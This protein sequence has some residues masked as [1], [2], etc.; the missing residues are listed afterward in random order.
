MRDRFCAGQE[1]EVRAKVAT[2]EACFNYPIYALRDGACHHT[3]QKKVQLEGEVN[4][5]HYIIFCSLDGWGIDIQQFLSL[6]VR[7]G[8]YLRLCS[9]DVHRTG[10]EPLRGP[11]VFEHKSVLADKWDAIFGTFE[12]QDPEGHGWV[13]WDTHG[14]CHITPGLLDPEKVK[15]GMKTYAWQVSAQSWGMADLMAAEAEEEAGEEDPCMDENGQVHREDLLTDAR[16]YRTNGVPIVFSVE[17]IE[18]EEDV[19]DG[20]RPDDLYRNYR[21][22]GMAVAVLLRPPYTREEC[23][24]RCA[25]AVRLF[26]AGVVPRC[27]SEW[28]CYWG[29]GQ[30]RP[31]QSPPPPRGLQEEL[32]AE[33]EDA[34]ANIARMHPGLAVPW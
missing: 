25:E 26:R 9:Y 6:T 2:D 15:E 1:S 17:L 21:S 10:L 14:M 30:V 8:A 13:D 5:E 22:L 23:L 7:N 12:D 20:P 33:G 28:Q 32:G 24:G 18:Q 19:R 3:Q 4:G 29:F 31:S 27:D 11:F 16:H 34:L